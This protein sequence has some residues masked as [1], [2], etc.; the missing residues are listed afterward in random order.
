MAGEA[1]LMGHDP[2]D[3]IHRM[4]SFVQIRVPAFQH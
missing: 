2:V 3:F 4:D 1:W